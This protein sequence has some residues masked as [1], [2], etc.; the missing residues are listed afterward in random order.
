MQL[1]TEFPKLVLAE[2]Q[3][4]LTALYNE[5]HRHYHNLNHIAYCEQEYKRVSRF[6]YDTKE[7]TFRDMREIGLMVL[8]HDAVY[9]VGPD[10]EAGENERLSAELFLQ[11]SE[12][13]ALPDLRRTIVADGIRY[14]AEHTTALPRS[15]MSDSQ[16][17][18]L[19]LDL[20]SMGASY[21]QFVTN[22][23][24]IRLEYA[25]VDDAAF[26][27]GRTAFF[28]TLITRPYI[29]YHHLMRGLYEET[30]RKNIDRWLSENL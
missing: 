23:D 18:F 10:V 30:T 26:K 19:D 25:W 1:L 13:K 12:A 27:A 29:Y 11:S 22:G 15:L 5:S 8:F 21:E 24:N 2:T 20:C 14:S 4:M 7:L 16:Q 28:R 17:I 9:N 6:L 3:E